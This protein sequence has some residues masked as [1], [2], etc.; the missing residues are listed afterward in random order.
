[1]TL[2]DLA[3][4]YGIAGV[5]CS[6]AVLR[7]EHGSGSGTAIWSAIATVPLCPL[8]A[9]F[10]LATPRTRER[11]R[12]PPRE[13]ASAGHPAEASDRAQSPRSATTRSADGARARIE[14]ALDESVKAVAGTPMSHVFSRQ[15][16][17][18]IS[19][20]VAAVAVRMEEL[21]SLASSPGLD[22]AA[23]AARVAELSRAGAP[24]RTIATAR[25]QHESLLR[26]EKLRATDG[27][28]LD[29]LADLL[30]ALRA[31]LLVA[32]YAGSPSDGT[33][34]IV[35]EVWARLEGLGAAFEGGA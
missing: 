9:P 12:H 18:R 23:S 30:E 7:K 2:T 21:G 25:L 19:A 6:I 33:G 1:M 20:E 27:E 5:A 22:P 31:Q 29:E 11:P 4:L 32:R 15:V 16:A 35:S 28:A 26:L 3:V 24:E 10:V 34:A 13:S 17:Q 8:W 14:V